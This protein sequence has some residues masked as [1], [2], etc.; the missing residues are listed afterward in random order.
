M[1]NIRNVKNKD[2]TPSSS[3]FHCPFSNPFRELKYQESVL[4]DVRQL[5]A[6][7]F[8]FLYNIEV[9]CRAQARSAGPICWLHISVEFS[10]PCSTLPASSKRASVE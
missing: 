6:M 9:S 10:G 8:P 2:L 7:S 5:S 3:H 4:A 1:R